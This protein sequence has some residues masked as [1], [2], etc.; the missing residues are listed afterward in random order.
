MTDRPCVTQPWAL[1]TDVYVPHVFALTRHV[2]ARLLALSSTTCAAAAAMA[3]MLP[4][5]TIQQPQPQHQMHQP[6][7]PQQPQRQP[8]QRR[9]LLSS[10]H[11]MLL[12]GLPGCSCT[13]PC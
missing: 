3:A 7:A 12:L 9:C 6:A 10:W 4:L 1:F 11:S 13:W 8:Q 2:Q 5:A